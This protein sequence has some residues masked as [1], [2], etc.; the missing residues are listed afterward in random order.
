MRCSLYHAHWIAIHRRGVC[1][2]VRYR[3][4]E[5]TK[6]IDSDT[7]GVVWFLRWQWAEEPQCAPQPLHSS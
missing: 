4:V 6:S 3:P 2:R 1:I 5:V 7:D